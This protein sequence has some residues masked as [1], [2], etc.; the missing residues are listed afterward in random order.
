MH[1]KL[2]CTYIFK[3]LSSQS[4]IF[5][6]PQNFFN[7][8]KMFPHIQISSS[9]Y[10]VSCFIKVS[11]NLTL[12]YLMTLRQSVI[13]FIFYLFLRF[14]FLLSLNF[15]FLFSIIW[16]KSSMSVC[17]PS[18]VIRNLLVLFVKVSW[19]PFTHPALW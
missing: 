1:E 6:Q 12:S 5:Q 4:K 16:N 18:E 14:L 3:T 7:L 13:I 10:S 8:I 19:F 15:R 9:L 2:I 11:L 17:C